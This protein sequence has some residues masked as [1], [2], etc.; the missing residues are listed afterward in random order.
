MLVTGFGNAFAAPV[1]SDVLPPTIILTGEV[2]DF[3]PYDT[4]PG[5]NPDFEGDGGAGVITGQVE[6]TLGGDGNPVFL[7]PVQSSFHSA[8]DFDEW[9]NDDAHNKLSS[10]DFTLTKISDTPP[11]YQFDSNSFFPID[12]GTTTCVG[13]FFGNDG[14]EDPP[15]NSIAHNYHFTVHIPTTFVYKSG[16]GQTLKVTD[17]DDDLFYFI[18]G[19]LAVDLGGVHGPETAGDV[20]LDTQAASLGLVDGQTYP[21]DIF[22]AERHTTLSDFHFTTFLVE[23]TPECPDPQNPI[24]NPTVAGELVPLNTTALFISGLSSSMIWMAPAVVGIAGVGVYYI[25]TH[26][27]EN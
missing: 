9:W 11:T 1:N 5:T 21:M 10:C 27:K 2:R 18:N 23:A 3:Q 14:F 4:T 8:A 6:S 17:S 15:T 12:D 20:N 24:C 7:L 22:F 13:S 16:T 25:K 26:N 19:K